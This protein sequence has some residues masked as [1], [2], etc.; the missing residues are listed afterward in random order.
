MNRDVLS[1]IE[2]KNLS[3]DMGKIFDIIK[4]LVEASKTQN[5]FNKSVVDMLSTLREMIKP[6]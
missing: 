2:I 6:S 1:E 5:E 3:E 4:Q